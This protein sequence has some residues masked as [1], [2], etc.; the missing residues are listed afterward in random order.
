MEV[1][2]FKQSR[3]KSVLRSFLVRPI[4]GERRADQRGSGWGGR[5]LGASC[6]RRNGGVGLGRGEAG[7]EE[8][9]S[10]N[11]ELERAES[12]FRLPWGAGVFRVCKERERF[13]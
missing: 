4:H 12:G 13:A 2:H 8:I 10:T 7:N 5:N 9:Q 3:S 6:P 11:K 1:S